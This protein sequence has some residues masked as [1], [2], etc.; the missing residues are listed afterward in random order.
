MLI[1]IFDDELRA[2][3]SC[4]FM[5]M[6]NFMNLIYYVLKIHSCCCW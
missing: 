2:L 3:K 5:G 6:L 1:V 4:E